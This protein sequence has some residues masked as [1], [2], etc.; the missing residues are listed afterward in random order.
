M[1]VIQKIHFFYN[2]GIEKTLS[3]LKTII[4]FFFMFFSCLESC[5]ILGLPVPGFDTLI[6]FQ[7]FLSL[8][9]ASRR[10]RGDQ[11]TFCAFNNSVYTINWG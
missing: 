3:L 2:S 7:E 10:D 8:G 6:I 1:L 4:I 11:N 9:G 5:I